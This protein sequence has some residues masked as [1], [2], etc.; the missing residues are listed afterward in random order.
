M[1]IDDE[2]DTR[3][4]LKQAFDAPPP[5]SNFIQKLGARLEQLL[6]QIPAVADDQG[7]EPVVA[8]PT[9]ALRPR[10]RR[11]WRGA[12]IAAAI[13]IAAGVFLFLARPWSRQ[14]ARPVDQQAALD[15][16]RP[17]PAAKVGARDPSATDPPMRE[18]GRLNN[19]QEVAR[20][21]VIAR[22]RVA[23]MV[24][25]TLRCAV[26]RTVYGKLLS[27][28]PAP[29]TVDVDLADLFKLREIAARARLGPKASDVEV[30]NAAWKA[31]GY[32][33]G[34]DVIFYLNQ[35]RKTASGVLYDLTSSAFDA[36]EH[37]L[38]DLE[39]TIVAIIE[40]GSYL[41]LESTGKE[42]RV[43]TD[44]MTVRAQLIDLSE[45]SARWKVTAVV[46]GELE[47]GFIVIDHEVFH[48]R[49]QAIAQHRIRQ[50]GQATRTDEI[51]RDIFSALLRRELAVG[52]EALL[53]VSPVRKTGEA[54]ECR[55]LA[56]SYEAEH[57][58]SP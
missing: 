24:G 26:T 56:R 22:G 1:R 50:T 12:A 52:R 2:D 40:D 18:R 30:Q 3:R 41:E 34:R 9:D 17:G 42:V 57:K 43:A 53:L 25:T 14:S 54:M 47:K 8:T 19:A 5:S 46:S 55:L 48:L 16:E 49:A 44:G 51:Q 27:D 37:S 6:A 33:V 31:M 58:K 28:A 7:S 39:G 23:A 29:A 15:P 32:E 10:S 11:W 21:S 35:P 45:S 20:A 4:L 36:P 38:D 13:A